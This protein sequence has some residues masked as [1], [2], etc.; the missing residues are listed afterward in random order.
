MAEGEGAGRKGREGKQLFF[1]FS[2]PPPGFC[3][4][5]VSRLDGKSAQLAEQSKEDRLT[6]CLDL[7]QNEADEDEL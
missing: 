1:S 6:L 2:P 4:R 7:R 3:R 5:T